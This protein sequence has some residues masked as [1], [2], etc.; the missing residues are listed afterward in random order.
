VVDIHLPRPRA[1]QR[2]SPE[3]AKLVAAVWALIR[4]E[5]A[6]AIAEETH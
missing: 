5:A 6:Q 4:D 1:E 2:N 3:L